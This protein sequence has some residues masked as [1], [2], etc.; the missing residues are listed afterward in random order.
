M[1]TR[2]N[3]IHVKR[4]FGPV[5]E[6]EAVVSKE[7]FSPRYDLDRTTGVITKIGH[8]L[9]GVH[10]RD[11]ILVTP[12]AKGGVAAGWAF[13]D[14]KSK[15]FAPKALIFGKTNPVMVQG[16]VF[17]GL[18]ITEGWIPNALEAIATGDIIR[19]NPGKKTIEV[20]RRRSA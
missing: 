18:A 1:T 16:A 7:G 3:V 17:A 4:A 2:R 8:A 14:I 19:V 12:T 6:G 20:L 9:E 13:F 10:L 5:V 11:K 15:G